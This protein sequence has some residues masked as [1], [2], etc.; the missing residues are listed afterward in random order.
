MQ[1]LAL[2]TFSYIHCWDY[3]QQTAHVTGIGGRNAPTFMSFDDV[4][5]SRGPAQVPKARE[6]YQKNQIEISK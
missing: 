2:S 4:S 1:T 3:P 5:G 6:P